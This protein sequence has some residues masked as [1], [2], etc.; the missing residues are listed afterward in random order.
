ML[1]KIADA[2]AAR[3]AKILAD[4]AIA[5]K[6]AT[7]M[8]FKKPAP[9]ATAACD[10]A[11]AA[12]P[13]VNSSKVFLQRHRDLRLLATP[14]PH[15]QHRIRRDDRGQPRGGKRDRRGHRAAERGYHPHHHPSRPAGGAGLGGR[16]RFRGPDGARDRGDG[17]RGGASGG[18]HH[19]GR[20]RLDRV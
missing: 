18:C 12:M 16:R 7:R 9:N 15:P 3:R 5:G 8:K 1:A 4:A 2:K 14:P 6:N 11:F 20:G 13:S 19:R 10:L 17:R